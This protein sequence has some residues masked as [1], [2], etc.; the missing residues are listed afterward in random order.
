ME[1]ARETGSAA[2]VKAEPSRA[3]PLG[4]KGSSRRRST[5]GRGWQTSSEKIQGPLSHPISTEDGHLNGRERP[6]WPADK[7]PVLRR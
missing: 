7:N 3:P 6:V 2:Q 1:A 4:S 5:D